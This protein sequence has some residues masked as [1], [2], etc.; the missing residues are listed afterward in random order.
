MF[1]NSAHKQNNPYVSTSVTFHVYRG[2]L[3]NI[4]SRT[5]HTIQKLMQQLCSIH[6]KIYPAP[7]YRGVL[8]K[9]CS[10]T[11]SECW[12][13]TLAL[14]QPP[15]SLTSGSSGRPQFLWMKSTT[16]T[17]LNR[18]QLLLLFIQGYIYVDRNKK[19]FKKSKEIKHFVEKRSHL[20]AVFCLLVFVTGVIVEN[21]KAGP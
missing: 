4:Q 6:L 17:F 11:H 19:S 8:L 9:C 13:I 12:P 14:T 18:F 10:A 21:K 2:S 15:V 7:T 20:I 16:F 5:E 3:Y 1:S